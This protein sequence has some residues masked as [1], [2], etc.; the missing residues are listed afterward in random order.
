M[1][2]ARS[3]HRSRPARCSARRLVPRA[4]VRTRRP[5]RARI[6]ALAATVGESEPLD[7]DEAAYAYIGHRILHGDVLYRDL[8]ENKPPL[9]YWLYTLAVAIGGYH[10]LTIRLMP[11]PFVLATIA[12]VWW[13][14]LR[15]GGPARGLA[16]G[17][18][19]RPAE[20][21]SVPVRQ[22]S[23]PRTLHQLFAVL[24][25]A[26]II[27]A[28]RPAGR[29]WFLAAGMCLG[30]AALVKQVALAHGSRRSSPRSR[31]EAGTVD[32]PGAVAAC[33]MS[34]RSLAWTAGW[35][36]W[37]RRPARSSGAG[38]RPAA[39]EDI[40]RPRR[41]RWRPTRSPSPNAPPRRSAGSPATPI[42]AGKL[43]WPFG[44]TDYLVWWGTGSWPLWLVSVPAAGL[45][46]GW[47]RAAT[48]AVGWSRPGRSRPGSRSPFRVSTGRTITSCRSPGVA[49]V[50]GGRAG[51]MRSGRSG[52]DRIDAGS[53]SGSPRPLIAGA[54]LASGRPSSRSAITWSSRPRS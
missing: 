23:E 20:H 6:H 30:A 19:Y 22:R 18:L 34:G 12:L 44:T 49:I 29:R 17:G 5:R 39:Y 47:R 42:P 7:C 31:D 2:S 50:V 25:L 13:I 10:E 40:V 53:R 16:G 46:G 54:P 9:G 33:S 24:A 27:R 21:R 35:W 32:R 1:R 36:R 48:H 51:A 43:P 14:G 26:M 52:R 37:R 4:Y 41:G 8:T 28:W 15:L 3:W 38:R 11:I 45:S